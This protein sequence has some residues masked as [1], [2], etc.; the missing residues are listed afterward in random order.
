MPQDGILTNIGAVQDALR[1]Y[2]KVVRKEADLAIRS[3]MG[4]IAL[5]AAKNTYFKDKEAIKS[6][7]ANLP[8]TKNSGVTRKGNGQWVGL[9][10]L[11]NWERKNKGLRPLGNSKNRVVGSTMRGI[12]YYNPIKGTTVT[13]YR[14]VQKKK[15]NKGAENYMDGK[16]KK[17]M[18][19]RAKSSR[20]LRIGWIR[21]AKFFGKSPSRGD[22]GD[23]AVARIS[24]DFYGTASVK[25]FAESLIEYVMTNTAGRFDTRYKRPGSSVT[26]QRSSSDQE[27]ASKII[28]R[29]LNLGVQEVFADIMK[30][31]ESRMPRVRAAMAQINKLK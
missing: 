3:K 18:N 12:S 25:H 14:L 10:K 17:F 20:L 2:G 22:F 28:E 8:I 11:I 31:F 27:R 24:G 19:A 21:A 5:R 30:Y 16:T 23:F 29:G 6:E 13:R 4:D 1:I 9:Y 26:R 7:L 15:R